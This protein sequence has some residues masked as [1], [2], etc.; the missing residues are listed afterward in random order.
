M[1]N[2]GKSEQIDHI[3]YPIK[4]D[5]PSNDFFA[6]ISKTSLTYTNSLRDYFK[7]ICTYFRLVK[8]FKERLNFLPFDQQSRGERYRRIF[9]T[10]PISFL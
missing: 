2:E 1:I 3:C 8:D 4:L 6:D 10:R 9:F 5:N 7:K